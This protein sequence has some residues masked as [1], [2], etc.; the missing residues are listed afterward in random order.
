MCIPSPLRAVAVI[1]GLA[2]NT[3][4]AGCADRSFP[5]E[6]NADLAAARGDW[7]EAAILAERFYGE[8]PTVTAKFK[9]AAA[10]QKIGQV[11]RAAALYEDVIFEG[12]ATPSQSVRG[13]VDS[14]ALS[15]LSDEAERRI[16]LMAVQIARSP[17]RL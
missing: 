4:T 11:Y 5:D 3:L 8:H 1:L 13:W 12:W 10:Y 17:Q 14:N 6:T 2:C 9:L 15:P 16:G 7:P